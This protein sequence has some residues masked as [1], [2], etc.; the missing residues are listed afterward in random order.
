MRIAEISPVTESVPPVGYGGTER[1]VSYLTEEL[2]RQGHQVTLFASG[3]SKTSAELVPICP[4]ATR[5]SKQDPLPL[6]VMELDRVWERAEEFD[7]LHFHLDY[8]HFPLFRRQPTPRITTIHNRIDMPELVPVFREFADE[9]VVAISASHRRQMDWLN[10]VGTIHHGLPLDLYALGERP[11][12]YFAFVGRASPDKGV[13]EAIAIARRAGVKLKLAIKVDETGR[14]YFDR[15]V[16]PVLGDDVE[17]VGEVDQVRKQ[18]FLGRARGLIFPINWP[19]PFGLV[20][21]EAMACGTPVIAFPAG[22]VPEIVEDGLT[23]FVCEDVPTAARR[24][25]DVAALSRR[26]CRDA[27]EQ[28]W[29]A[30]RMARDYVSL[31]ERVIADRGD[32]MGERAS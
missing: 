20:M 24:I 8:L 18:E 5:R 13:V 3:D 31:F 26:R 9:P 23:G 28:R 30:P 11:D 10:W 12:D 22:S 6:H 7:V 27:F 17:Y 32:R 2:V 14:D 21:V 15:E 25:E 1:V 19:E 16:E 29:S 4:H